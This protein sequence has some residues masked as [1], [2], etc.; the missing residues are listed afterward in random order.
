MKNIITIFTGGT[1]GS[2]KNASGEI[3]PEK[4]MSYR[5]LEM[6]REKKKQE[7]MEDLGAEGEQEVRFFSEEPYYILSENLSGKELFFYNKLCNVLDH[8]LSN[9]N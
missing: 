8:L 1:I 3:A 7:F 9:E 5:L 6:Y 2:K 4:G